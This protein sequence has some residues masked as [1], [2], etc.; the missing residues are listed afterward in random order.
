MST[1]SSIYGGSRESPRDA[2]TSLEGDDSEA[3]REE[4]EAFANSRRY[5][6]R[7]QGA[8]SR[9]GDDNTIA[10]NVDEQTANEDETFYRALG[11][12]FRADETIRLVSQEAEEAHSAAAAAA[13]VGSARR[14]NLPPMS[15]ERRVLRMPRLS[16][17]P[18]R[19]QGN[20][21]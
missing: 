7:S 3:R 2:N 20:T 21:H 13:T 5:H 12:L 15:S 14:I 11:T 17:R 8:N 18:A 1:L 9:Q 4:F 10:S 6:R 19:R 16:T